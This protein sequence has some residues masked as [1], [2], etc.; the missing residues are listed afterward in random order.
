MIERERVE[1]IAVVRLAHGAVSAMDLELCEA[2]TETFTAL[3]D[4]PADAVVLTGT[5]RAFSAGVDLR[6]IVDGGAE[7]VDRFLPALDAA[8]R[9]AFTLPKP[10]VAAVNGHAIAGGCVLAACA[11]AVL[12]ADGPGR[13]GVPEIKV[14]VPFPQVPLQVLIHAVGSTGARR[15]VMGAQTYEPAAARELGLVDEVVAAGE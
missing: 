10:L 7:Y 1:R 4:D 6:R 2:I 13:I 8:F 12:M 3:A 15:L 9:A 14:G 11:D 5:G